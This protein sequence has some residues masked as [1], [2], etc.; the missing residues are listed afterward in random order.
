MQ[1]RLPISGLFLAFSISTG[2]SG[3]VHIAAAEEEEEMKGR[4]HVPSC[5]PASRHAD[6]LPAAALSNPAKSSAPGLPS[7]ALASN[8]SVWVPPPTGSAV[9]G[10]GDSLGSRTL[11]LPRGAASTSSLKPPLQVSC[12]TSHTACTKKL[13]SHYG[14]CIYGGGPA[15]ALWSPAS[16][17]TP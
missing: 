5:H 3:T 15:E 8:V 16:L 11:H 10:L 7:L 2:L 12:M 6:K 9:N 1:G 17:L 13:W 14:L 4:L